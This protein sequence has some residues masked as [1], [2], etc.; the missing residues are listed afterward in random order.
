M[1]QNLI[2]YLYG[3]RSKIEKILQQLQLLDREPDPPS[4]IVT[5]TI[6]Q[7]PGPK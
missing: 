6:E 7:Q 3:L 1:G 5:I 4:Q 2:V